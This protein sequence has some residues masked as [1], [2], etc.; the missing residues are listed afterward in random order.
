VH[1]TLEV[2]RDR[3]IAEMDVKKQD[4][5]TVETGK[6]GG[7][8]FRVKSDMQQKEKRMLRKWKGL[9]VVLEMI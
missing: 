8:R 9:K 1:G 4:V 6:R 5:E 3:D 2:I 7:M